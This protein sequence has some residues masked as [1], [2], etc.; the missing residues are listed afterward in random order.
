MNA[1][2]VLDF[3]FGAPGE[4]DFGK[5]RPLW[6][7]KSDET[8]QLIR[9]RFGGV[10]ESALRSEL[11]FWQTA[12]RDS[13]ALI[14]VLDQFARNVYRDTP[15]SFAGDPEALRIASNLVDRGEHRAL[16]PI[17]RWFA[18]MPFEHSEFLND[19][20]ES[21][22]LFEELAADG[23]PDPLPWA[24]KHFDVIKRFGRFPHRNSILGRTST[25]EEL[26]FLNEPGSRF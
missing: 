14:I 18:Y 3:W 13:L 25:S 2:A 10:L 12:P 5:A 24:I 11:A 1:N 17:E 23:L 16:R 8:D 26:A 19:Q 22:R 20:H 6:F 9:E 15:R 7:T 4:A 21:V